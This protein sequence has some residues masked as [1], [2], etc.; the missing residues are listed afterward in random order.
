[1][2]PDP[3]SIAM[4]HGVHPDLV[5]V[6]VAVFTATTIPF[7]VTYGVCTLEAE[8]GM[9]AR[10]VSSLKDPKSCRHVPT[11]NPPMGH[12]VDISILDH[13]GNPQWGNQYIHAY[14]SVGKLF[15]EASTNLKIPVRSGFMWTTFKDWGHH[16]LP[17]TKYP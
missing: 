13:E 7:R 10:G 16:E 17:V 3:K 2:I 11:G 4:M 14:I 12:A 1:M 15:Q 8:R 5:K 9:I 6:V